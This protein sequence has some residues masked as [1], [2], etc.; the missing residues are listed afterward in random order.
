VN[1]AG[2]ERRLRENLVAAGVPPDFVEVELG[3]VMEVLAAF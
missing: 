3:R 1:P 2:L